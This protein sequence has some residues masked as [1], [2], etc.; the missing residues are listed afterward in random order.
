MW[1]VKGSPLRG[2]ALA[3]LAAALAVVGGGVAKASPTGINVDSPN[4]PVLGNHGSIY[5]KP[6]RLC[7]DG[8]CIGHAFHKVTSVISKTFVGGNQ[9]DSFNSL[10]EGHLSIENQEVGRITLTGVTDVTIFGRTS[11]TETGSFDTQMTS[12][13]LTGSFGGHS[14]EIINDPSQT[15][16][17]HTTVEQVAPHEWHINSFFDVFTELSLDNGP[18]MPATTGA[19]HVDLEVAE[20]ATLSLVGVGVLALGLTRLHSRRKRGE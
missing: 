20:P 6:K 4:L 15:S 7:F 3:V 1:S 19:A 12:L 17:G 5:Y 9:L 8:I 13:D 14:I 16:S 11:D 18:F 2:C 10:Y